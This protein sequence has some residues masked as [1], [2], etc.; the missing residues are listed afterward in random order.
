MLIDVQAVVARPELADFGLSWLPNKPRHH[1]PNSTWLPNVGYGELDA[2]MEHYFRTQLARLTAHDKHKPIVIYCVFDCWMS[3]NAVQRATDYGYRAVYW[4][5]DGTDGWQAQGLPLV[6]G[7]P[8]PL[9][10]TP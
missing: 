9:E 2:T 3:W 5:R 1:L 7:Q 10:D 4:Y 6:E 8:V